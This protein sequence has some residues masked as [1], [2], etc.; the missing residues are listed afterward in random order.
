MS[1]KHTIYHPRVNDSH[2]LPLGSQAS[3]V[4][5]A[6]RAICPGPIDAEVPWA[7]STVGS[8]SCEVAAATMQASSSGGTESSSAWSMSGHLSGLLIGRVR[9]QHPG[10]RLGSA[11]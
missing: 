8:N 6:H 1:E 7:K 11:G 2:H 3:A 10:M 5:C 9:K 4:E